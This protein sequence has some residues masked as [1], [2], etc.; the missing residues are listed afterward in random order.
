[1][2]TTTAKEA[3]KAAKEKGLKDVAAVREKLTKAAAA[4][5]A[6]AAAKAAK[7]VAAAEAKAAKVEKALRADLRKAYAICDFVRAGL[8]DTTKDAAVQNGKAVGGLDRLAH[9][10]SKYAGPA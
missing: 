1:M 8:M 2:A 10:L 7:A 5:E 6:K 3:V 9:V 4:A